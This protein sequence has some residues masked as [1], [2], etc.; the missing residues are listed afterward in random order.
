MNHLKKYMAALL[1]VAATF[2]FLGSTQEAKAIGIH[3]KITFGRGTGCTKK[4]V[5]DVDVGVDLKSFR[6]AGRSG[7]NE[8]I[9]EADAVVEN[10]YLVITFKKPMD[11]RAIEDAPEGTPQGK[12]A[13]QDLHVTFHGGDKFSFSKAAAEKLGFSSL[14]VADGDYVLEGKTLKIK[15][16]ESPTKGSSTN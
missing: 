8:A 10:G 16:R 3:V 6:Q 5:C 12:V 11:K 9:V 7:T 15:L 4:G 14:S 1:V 2:T 13:M